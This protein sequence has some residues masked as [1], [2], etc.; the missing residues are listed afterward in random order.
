MKKSTIKILLIELFVII[1]LFLNNFVFNI[2][3]VKELNVFIILLLAF[4]SSILLLGYEKNRYDGQKYVTTTTFLITFLFQ[5]F[6]FVLF[7]IISGFLKNSYTLGITHFFKI[8][9]PITGI[10]IVS[11]ILRHQLLKKG[12]SSKLVF[13]LTILFFVIIDIFTNISLYDLGTNKGIFELFALVIAPSIV[14]NILL[15]FVVFNKGFIP[16]IVYKL[17]MMLPAYYL[18]VYPDIGN[19]MTSIINILFPFILFVLFLEYMELEKNKKEEIEN[20]VMFKLKNI[21][22]IVIIIFLL[23]IIGLSSGIF[24]YYLLA[25]GSGSMEPSISTGDSVLIEKIDKY[26]KLKI[27]DILVYRYDKKVIVHRITEIN[28]EEGNYTF[29]TKGDNNKQEDIWVIDESKVIGIVKFK[30]PYVGVPVVKFNQLLGG[31]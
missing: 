13:V 14:R 16:A 1:F 3:K 5:T 27:G 11:E 7:G 19:Y 23:I 24:K 2:F 22:S 8:V 12:S 10:I 9:F 4:I 31:I 6:T 25:I 15:S 28:N 30:I 26:D 17:I 18:P 20:P 21:I 29:K